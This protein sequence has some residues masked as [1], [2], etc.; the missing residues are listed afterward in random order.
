MNKRVR[1]KVFGPSTGFNESTQRRRRRE[2]K[3][4]F[5]G[6]NPFSQTLFHF[7][8]LMRKNRIFDMQCVNKNP[9]A[10]NYIVNAKKNHID[11]RFEQL[12]KKT[13][14]YKNRKPLLIIHSVIDLPTFVYML[15]VANGNGQ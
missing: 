1:H 5:N 10:I 13:P 8:C 2:Y 15:L 14:F 7:M 3:L 4:D 11:L 12:L 6:N 9:L